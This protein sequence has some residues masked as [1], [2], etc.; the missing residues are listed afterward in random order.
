M[1]RITVEVGADLLKDIPLQ[2]EAVIRQIFELGLT[3]LKI[4]IA[5]R[6]YREGGISLGYAAHLVG[7]PKREI[8]L[9]AR[10]RGMI[11]RFSE[12]TVR[13]E[14]GESKETSLSREHR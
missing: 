13:E 7:I 2:D 4:E 11:P 9:Q 8:I 14:L 5:F 1:S 6:R 3:Q 10:A 12:Q